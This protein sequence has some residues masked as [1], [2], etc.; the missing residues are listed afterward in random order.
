MLQPKLHPVAGMPPLH[1]EAETGGQVS[2]HSMNNVIQSSPGGQAGCHLMSLTLSL[3]KLD[4]S[5]G[6]TWPWLLLKLRSVRG[7]QCWIRIRL[8]DTCTTFPTRNL[9]SI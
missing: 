2:I 8:C 1:F 5:M 7:L 6:E 3:S 9:H 4:L